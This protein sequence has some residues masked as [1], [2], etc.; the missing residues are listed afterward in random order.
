MNIS[1]LNLY[2]LAT[3]SIRQN[4]REEFKDLQNKL[5]FVYPMLFDKSTMGTSNSLRDFLS[6]SM[7]K[8]LFIS[9]AFNMVKV[10][11][12]VYPLTDERGRQVNV[13]ANSTF[14]S[15]GVNTAYSGTEVQRNDN[16]DTRREAQEKIKE[17]T[18]IIKKYLD[19]DP[20]LKSLRP[21]V[22]I[23]TMDNFVDVPV[24]IGTKAFD[25]D[26]RIVT[27]MMIVAIGK[28]LPL[29]SKTNIDKIF[30]EIDSL[31][32]DDQWKLNNLLNNL[33]KSRDEKAQNRIAEFFKGQKN[34]AFKY[35]KKKIRQNRWAS[36]QQNRIN[37][38]KQKIPSNLRGDVEETEPV[39]DPEEIFG[40]REVEESSR[41]QTELFFKFCFDETL[42]ARQFG[43]D[44][45]SGQMQTVLAKTSGTFDSMFNRTMQNYSRELTTSCRSLLHSCF[46]ILYSKSNRQ[47]TL[48]FRNDIEK[49]LLHDLNEEVDT[50]VK[51]ALAAV[52]GSKKPE[53]AREVVARLKHMCKN[54]TND[55]N[56]KNELSSMMNNRQI[57]SVAF[58]PQQLGD[59]LIAIERIADESSQQIRS[60]EQTLKT[61]FDSSDTNEI[62]GSINRI[63][64]EAASSTMKYFAPFLSDYSDLVCHDK[65]CPGSGMD[66]RKDFI[67]VQN[68]ISNAIQGFLSYVFLIEFQ[69]SLCSYIEYVEIEIETATADVR[70]DLNYTLV[71][72]MESLMAIANVIVARNWKGLVSGGNSDKVFAKSTMSNTYMMSVVKYIGN[73]LQVPN[74]MVVDQQ[75]GE[76]YYKLM[77]QSKPQ[78]TKLNTIDT[79]VKLSQQKELTQTNTQNYF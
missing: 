62:V 10:A 24:I 75:R 20:R 7:L 48:A 74:L 71:L 29:T 77:H 56:I 21:Y 32:E 28:G 58:G 26:P 50:S 18:A 69:S 42:R 37:Q 64:G 27:M 16:V 6:T 22:E 30:K 15:D 39:Y 76:V 11:S 14:G 35:A 63:T 60:I 38:W 25:I 31:Y 40:I 46:N 53:D 33:T 34:K 49:K 36:M 52:L 73:K 51:V 68:T 17:K 59:S 44:T 54:I 78:K 3:R 1:G 79:F 4:T 9:N 66:S 5:V 57:S 43:I 23:I 13:S 55:Q 12:Q 65:N 61:I 70:D 19:T 47:D 8:E 2:S 41:H 67:E 72:P 45:S